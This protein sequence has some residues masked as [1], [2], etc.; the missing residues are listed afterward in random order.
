MIPG[1]GTTLGVVLLA[2][3]VAA[4]VA[5]AGRVLS[6][7]SIVDSEHPGEALRAELETR[8][9]RPRAARLGLERS[10]AVVKALDLPAAV[11]GDLGQ[12]VRF[13][14]ERH[15]PFPADEAAFDFVPLPGATNGQRVLIV[16]AERRTV[17]RALG[18]LDAVKL[19]PRSLTVAAHD[20]VSLLDRRPRDEHAVWVHGV[21]HV[22]DLLLLS[23][24]TLAASRSVVT[25][26]AAGLANEIRRSLVMLKWTECD[27]LWISGDVP[28]G[29]RDS[30]ALAALRLTTDPPP[31]SARARRA[32]AAVEQSADGAELLAAALAAAPRPPRLDLLPAGLR[33]RR[34][35]VQQRVTIGMGIVTAFLGLGALLADSLREQRQ[36]GRVETEIRRL[37]PQVRDVQR[38]MEELER[39]RRLLATVG[40]FGAGSL[41]PLMLLRE[42]TETLPP[43][44]WLTTLSLDRKAAE[45]TGQAAAASTLIPLLE[46]SPRFQQVEF[47]SPVTRGRDKEQFRIRAAWEIP[48]G[49][50]AAAT[51]APGPAPPVPPRP[52]RTRGPAGPSP[53]GA[54]DQEPR[55]PN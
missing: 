15:V 28:P 55:E 27:A 54:A 2:D 32:L 9:F 17:E 37:D 7:F 18:V 12:M 52:S 48:P 14:L 13:D 1:R 4:A 34:L 5:R 29:I 42:L 3:R 33:P 23:G 31:L 39:Q 19:R 21:G 51:P 46:N 43:D 36:L 8:G 26:D 45:M 25:D 16:A 49:V 50:M 30:R 11:A 40:T 35:S 41:H 44:V 20:L 47:A 6:S 53:A 24:N 22:T 10:L 38:V